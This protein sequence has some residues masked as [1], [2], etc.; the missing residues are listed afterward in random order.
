MYIFYLI[1]SISN[2]FILD[3]SGMLIIS[4][5]IANIFIYDFE[6]LRLKYIVTASWFLMGSPNMFRTCGFKTKH[7]LKVGR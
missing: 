3:S 1:I 2:P 4:V 5:L 6:Y 7:W